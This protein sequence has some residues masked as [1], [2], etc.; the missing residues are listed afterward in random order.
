MTA[1]NLEVRQ[2]RWFAASPERVWQ[3]W[4]DPKKMAT[5]FAPLGMSVA[6]LDADV[7]VGGSFRIVMELGQPM[8]T[9]IPQFG[10]KVIASGT[11]GR[12]EE[13]SVLGFTWGWDG[14]DEVSHVSI[15]M[16]PLDN[17]TDLV[18]HQRKIASVESQAF[19]A[20]G[21]RLTLDHLEASLSTGD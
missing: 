19:H 14:H 9:L 20:D 8:G 12:V 2:S 16:R 13:P 7:V 5:W 18:L 10:G 17:G 11:Y 4:V 3:A 21:W 1:P 15:T 6:D